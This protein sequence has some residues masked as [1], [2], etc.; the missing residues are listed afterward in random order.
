[1]HVVQ[2]FVLLSNTPDIEI[3]EA[4]LPEPAVLF[5]LDRPFSATFT[6]RKQRKGN[7]LFEFAHDVGWSRCGRFTNQKMY[8]LGHDNV[9]HKRKRELLTHFAKN[10][11]E[12][13]SRVHG[14]Q[15]WKALIATAGDEVQVSK[16]VASF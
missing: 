1:V 10:L 9:S 5:G 7:A 15:K 14:A 8:M 3:V 6:G 16:T 11:Y 4:G 12:T 13:I 2:F